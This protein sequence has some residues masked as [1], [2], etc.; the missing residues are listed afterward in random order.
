M[1][2]WTPR[3]A[4]VRWA[5]SSSNLSRSGLRAADLAANWRSAL[6]DKTPLDSKRRYGVWAES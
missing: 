3:S 2:G 6:R 4:S 5:D 1:T